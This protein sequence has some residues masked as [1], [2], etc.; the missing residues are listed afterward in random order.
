LLWRNGWDSRMIAELLGVREASVWNSMTALR[1]GGN[2]AIRDDS[3]T[4]PADGK[5]APTAR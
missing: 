1:G 3:H 5:T 4:R 2:A